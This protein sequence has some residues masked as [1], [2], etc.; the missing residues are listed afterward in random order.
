[1]LFYTY[2]EPSAS[3]DGENTVTVQSVVDNRS[4]LYKVPYI[5]VESVAQRVRVKHT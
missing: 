4:H 2:A 1:M 5:A 3:K